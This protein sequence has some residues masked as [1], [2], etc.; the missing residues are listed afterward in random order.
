[1]KA[2]DKIKLKVIRRKE[3]MKATKEF[4]KDFRLRTRTKHE[5][6]QVVPMALLSSNDVLIRARLTFVRF[7]LTPN[8]Q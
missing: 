6:E 8:N 4:D 5:E 3:T 7:G 2:N 1:M